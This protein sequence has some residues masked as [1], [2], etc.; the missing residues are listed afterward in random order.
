MGSWYSV[1]LLFQ[2]TIDGRLLEQSLCEESIRILRGESDE[3]ARARA[4]EIG[5]SAEHEYL[6]ESG[7]V[8]RW[9]FVS[10]LE[11]QDLSET[12]LQDG[13][14]VFSTLIRSDEK[15]E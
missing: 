10:V 2:S 12:E 14:E 5:R 6:N 15:S 13:M 9:N 7:E 8:V 11:L 3:Q 1:K 4:E